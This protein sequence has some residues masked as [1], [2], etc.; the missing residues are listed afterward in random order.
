MEGVFGEYG[1]VN[2]GGFVVRC[3]GYLGVV[4][5]AGLCWVLEGRY[6]LLFL[7]IFYTKLHIYP[8][9]F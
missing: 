6:F 8:L 7:D 2:N 1:V 9:T 3:F 5:E 4:F